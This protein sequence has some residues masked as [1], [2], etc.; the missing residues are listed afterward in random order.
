MGMLLSKSE[1]AALEKWAAGVQPVREDEGELVT[2][3]ATS[4][5]A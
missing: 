1:Y 4:E 5:E 2:V 3:G